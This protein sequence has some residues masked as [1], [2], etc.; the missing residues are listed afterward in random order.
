RTVHGPTCRRLTCSAPTVAM[1][2]P[3]SRCRSASTARCWRAGACASATPWQSMGRVCSVAD[4][5]VRVE[6]DD[7]VAAVTLTRGDKHNALDIPMFEQIIAAG[8][9]VA[10]EPGG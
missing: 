10:G 9:R 4:E 7:H 1:S 8:E 5:R 3:R 6:I 2:T